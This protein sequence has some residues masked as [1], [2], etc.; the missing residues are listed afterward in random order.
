MDFADVM[1]GNIKEIKQFCPTCGDITV[2]RN[3]V[4]MGCFCRSGII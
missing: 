2:F 4:C 3:G 1:L